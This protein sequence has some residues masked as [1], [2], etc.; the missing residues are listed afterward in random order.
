[1]LSASGRRKIEM[2]D[3]STRVAGH[4]PLADFPSEAAARQLAHV[5][6]VCDA[7]GGGS[8]RPI[9]SG[10]ATPCGRAVKWLRS[11]GSNV[12]RRSSSRKRAAVRE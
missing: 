6:G 8:N 1:M 4:W 3:S 12:A 10:T 5:L 7:V 2:K 9:D 11:C